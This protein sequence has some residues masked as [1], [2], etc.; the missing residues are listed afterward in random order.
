MTDCIFLFLIFLF[1]IFLFLK[2][3]QH[4]KPTFMPESCPRH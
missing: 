3:G 4:H 2:L 1:L